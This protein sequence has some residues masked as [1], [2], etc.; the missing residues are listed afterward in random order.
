MCD[1]WTY[2]L[3]Q[4]PGWLLIA[5]GVAWLVLALGLTPW[6]WLIVSLA[7]LKDLAIL[8][9]MRRISGPPQ[10]GT[11]AMIGAPGKA[12]GRVAPSGYV[13][14]RGE[15]WEA[16]AREPSAEIPK[17]G[18]IVVREVRGLTLIVDE[19]DGNADRQHAGSRRAARE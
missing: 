12:V 2:L 18:R 6:L 5:G 3:S 4:V 17:G 19:A 9:A 8:L 1:V 16:R 14:V 15:L 11:T 7:I 10:T 13:R